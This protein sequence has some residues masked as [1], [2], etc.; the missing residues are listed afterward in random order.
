MSTQIRSPFEGPTTSVAPTNAFASSPS[1]MD[2][3]MGTAAASGTSSTFTEAASHLASAVHSHASYALANVK[4]FIE[5]R[6][7]TFWIVF[8]LAVAVFLGFIIYYVVVFYWYWNRYI[9]CPGC[10][11][12]YPDQNANIQDRSPIQSRLLTQ[13]Q[14]GYTYSM[15]LYLANWYNTQGYDK[16]KPVYCRGQ[17]IASDEACHQLKWNTVPYQQPGI[18]LNPTVNNLRVV[19]TTSATQPGGQCTTSSPSPA[20][21][22]CIVVDQDTEQGETFYIL[23]YVDQANV[24]IGQWF[25]LCVVVTQSR[26]EL[27]LNGKLTNTHVLVGECEF[28][29]E[30]CQVENGYFAPG[31]T[32]FTAR[33]SN[34]RYMPQALPIQMIQL[35]YDVEKNNPVLSYTNPL[36][37]LSNEEDGYWAGL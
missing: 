33:L 15:W 1:V 36:N 7:I 8:G 16:W 5:T 4:T 14:S 30:T 37:S 26:I 32:Q 12:R 22:G 3:S 19:V 34:F 20:A 25:N 27:Y 29:S 21:N 11:L 28:N 23:E 18:W 13:P 35:L 9:N 10:Y 17:Y 31:S 6:S 24:P 2:S